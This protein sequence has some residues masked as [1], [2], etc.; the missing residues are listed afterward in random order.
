VKT[1]LI[2]KGYHPDQGAR[3]LRRAIEYHIETPLSEEILKGEVKEGST[4]HL[5]VKDDKLVFEVEKEPAS[6]S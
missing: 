1:F 4:V 3:P 6:V 2:D 5:K